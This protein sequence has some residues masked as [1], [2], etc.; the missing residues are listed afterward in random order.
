MPTN[1]I[2]Q[3]RTMTLTQIDE[4]WVR[5]NREL[6][7]WL[8]MEYHR[9]VANRAVTDLL[10]ALDAEEQPEKKQLLAIVIAIAG[11]YVVELERQIKSIDVAQP[12]HYRELRRRVNEAEFWIKSITEIYSQPSELQK[13]MLDTLQSAADFFKATIDAELPVSEKLAT[14]SA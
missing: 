1:L 7:R 8:M 13:L 5:V 10:S 9:R 11:A 14:R 6:S 4:H 3:S 2:D 12:A